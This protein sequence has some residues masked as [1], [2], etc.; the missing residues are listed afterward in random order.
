MSWVLIGVT[1]MLAVSAVS[2][3]APEPMVSGDGC[4]QRLDAPRRKY[5]GKPDLCNR[6]AGAIRSGSRRYPDPAFDRMGLAGASLALGGTI[7][8]ATLGAAGMG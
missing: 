4:A 7:A 3:A 2:A 1:W 8:G 6:R 5:S